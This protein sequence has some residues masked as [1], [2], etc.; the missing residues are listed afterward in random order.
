MKR[1]EPFVVR[2]SIDRDYD[3]RACTCR[4]ADVRISSVSSRDSQ[5]AKVCKVAGQGKRRQVGYSALEIDVVTF[6]ISREM[7]ATSGGTKT[8]RR[9]RAK[10]SNIEHTA[11][12]EK[13][14]TPFL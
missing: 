3:R 13:D 12:R 9:D 5:I 4:L 1:I 6:R 7:M 11:E 8:Q 2:L 14:R 10:Q